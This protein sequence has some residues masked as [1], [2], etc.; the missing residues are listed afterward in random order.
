MHTKLIKNASQSQMNITD[1]KSVIFFLKV[2][3]T[4]HWL[5]VEALWRRWDL[6]WA[7]KV[8]QKLNRLEILIVTKKIQFNTNILRLK[9]KQEKNI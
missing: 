1:N 5:D 7:L 9:T 8:G 4:V 2:K 6:C 3:I